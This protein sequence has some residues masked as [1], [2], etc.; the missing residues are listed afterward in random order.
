MRRL[1]SAGKLP[2]LW[3]ERPSIEDR[4]NPR[5][6]RRPHATSRKGPRPARAGSPGPGSPLREHKHATGVRAYPRNPNPKPPPLLCF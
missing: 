3:G 2:R 5:P 1:R 6:P 4:A